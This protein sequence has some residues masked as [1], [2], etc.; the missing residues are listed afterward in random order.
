[1]NPCS[2]CLPRIAASIR[3]RLPPRAPSLRP[4]QRPSGAEMTRRVRLGVDLGGTKIAITALGEGD[5]ELFSRRRPTPRGDYSAS[6]GVIGEL[7]A[8][9]EQHLDCAGAASV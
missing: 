2:W 1:M 5:A 8:E 3:R 9:A 7:V 6:L 4:I